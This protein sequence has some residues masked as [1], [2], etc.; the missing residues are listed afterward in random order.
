MKLPK[1]VLALALAAFMAVT[2]A[3]CGQVKV[4]Y[5]DGERVVKEAPQLKT[6][7]DEGNEKLLAAEQ[8]AEAALQDTAGKSEEE[9]QKL[10][11]DAQRKLMGLNQQYTTRLQQTL[12]TALAEIATE[13]KL[14]AVV[15]NIE[16]QETVILGGIDV[17][18]DVIQKL[19]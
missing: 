8:E 4:G 14:D 1:R 7:M 5:F 10:G 2:M 19:Q 12:D 3:G 6:I 16:G 15:D 11:Q 18:E 13:R 17:T 9:I